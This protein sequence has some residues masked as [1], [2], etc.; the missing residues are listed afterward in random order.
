MNKH[1]GFTIVELIVVIVVIAIL[2]TIAVVSYGFVRGD[3]DDAKIRAVVKAVGD[4]VVLRESR[5]GTIPSRRVTFGGGG[6]TSDN[7]N[8]MAKE[9]KY[10]RQDFCNGL[11]GKGWNVSGTT[12]N[13]DEI[14]R[15]NECKDG[16]IAVYAGLNNPTQQDIEHAD[17]VKE[18]CGHKPGTPHNQL[19]PPGF[20]ADDVYTYAQ[21]F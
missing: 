12:N 3:A 11:R 8:K 7:I 17:K 6:A 18:A 15:W 21:R 20:R 14:F 13:C 16:G 9:G 19:T 1:K 5:E 10:L 4:A 2:A